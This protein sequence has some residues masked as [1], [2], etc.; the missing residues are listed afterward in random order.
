MVDPKESSRP[1][2]AVPAFTGNHKWQLVLMQLHVFTYEMF[3]ISVNARL[4]WA[5]HESGERMEQEMSFY[6]YFYME[7][8]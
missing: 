3:D 7:S 2:A 8:K 6:G 1:T 5:W 4:N